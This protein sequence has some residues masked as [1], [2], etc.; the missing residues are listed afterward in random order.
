ML[1]AITRG[2]LKKAQ[3]TW[4]IRDIFKWPV[5]GGNF[6]PIF[7]AGK[8]EGVKWP[9]EKRKRFNSPKFHAEK[10]EGVVDWKLQIK[11]GPYSYKVNKESPLGLFLSL[12]ECPVIDP[13]VT[14]RFSSTSIFDE[15][16]ET[17]LF[18]K[19]IDFNHSLSFSKVPD[20]YVGDNV[21]LSEHMLIEDL[22]KIMKIPQGLLIRFDIEYEKG[23]LEDNTPTEKLFSSKSGSD[24]SF[25]IAGQEIKAHKFILS[26]KSSVFAAM[27]KTGMNEEITDRIDIP[28]GISPYIFNELLRFIY[29][30]RAQLTKSNAE[31]LLA[32]S[33]RYSIRSL[34][35]KCEKNFIKQVTIENCI[36]MLNLALLHN[37]PNLRGSTVSEMTNFGIG[38]SP[39]FRRT[40]AWEIFKLA[41]PQ[42]AFHILEV[43]LSEAEE[44]Y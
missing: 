43:L 1:G 12:Y 26:A 8:E 14:A 19:K 25:I 20:C 16:G 29:T 11:K 17:L 18:E 41:Q 31:P 24:I 15:T 27:F 23:I 32:A 6:K 40:E 38:E 44:Y 37:A 10:E 35:Y 30:D 39:K 5:E 4:T 22:E 42:I 28:A 33:N 3:L 9:L 2:T 21:L 13:T 7:N 36:E 34:K